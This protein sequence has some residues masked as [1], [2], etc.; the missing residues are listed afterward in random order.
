[1]LETGLQDKICLVTGAASGIGRACAEILEGEGA[2]LA[3]TDRD[4]AGVEAVCPGATT[5][6]RRAGDLSDP[7]FVTSLA[8]DLE[9]RFGR[10]DVAVH[11][12][13][14]YT[15]TSW[16]EVGDDEWRSVLDVN[17][18]GSFLVAQAAMRLMGREGGR[19]VLCGSYAARTG[20]LRASAAYA[21]AKSGV[22]G[23]TRHL[24]LHGG[25]LG[26]RVNAIHPGMIETPMLSVLDDEARE[27]GRSRSPMGRLA[28]AEEA[29]RMAVVLV[30]DLASWVQ[31]VQLDVNG[32][33]H[34]A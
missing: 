25:P 28:T 30:S 24:A 31:G 14:V 21:A 19:I 15:T 1:M 26:I 27:D 4:S 34:M 12:A 13:G 11:M 3:L 32:G 20:G 29:A 17:L 22:I 8:A 16:D 33:M 9:H 10:L 5:A 18:H 6:L 7:A 23:L 2:T